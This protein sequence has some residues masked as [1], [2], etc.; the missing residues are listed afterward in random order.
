MPFYFEVSKPFQ[1]FLGKT[2]AVQVEKNWWQTAASLSNASSNL[3]TSC[4]PS[5]QSYLTLWATYILLIKFLSC[6][7]LPVPFMICINFSQY[8]HTSD[9]EAADKQAL[10]TP[11]VNCWSI[12]CKVSVIAIC[13]PM[14]LPWLLIAAAHKSDE[15]AAVKQ[16]LLPLSTR[17]SVLHTRSLHAS[18]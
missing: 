14:I 11:H 9:Q 5:V 17:A 13:V 10:S 7:S 6:Q 1:S 15:E 18:A 3:H 16:A 4:L 2:F 12:A 8:C